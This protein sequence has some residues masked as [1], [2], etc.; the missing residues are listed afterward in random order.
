MKADIV[1][2]YM[3]GTEN[4]ELCSANA[5]KRPATVMTWAGKNVA[6]DRVASDAG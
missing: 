2:L 6:N 5:R 4:R 3:L 1:L